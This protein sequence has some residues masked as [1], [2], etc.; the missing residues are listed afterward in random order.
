[1]DSTLSSAKDDGRFTE[2]FVKTMLKTWGEDRHVVDD[3]PLVSQRTRA[4]LRNKKQYCIWAH[5]KDGLHDF[6][7]GADG[8]VEARKE[9]SP[10]WT[11]WVDRVDV[12]YSNMHCVVE[13]CEETFRLLLWKYHNTVLDNSVVHPRWLIPELDKVFRE[14]TF[15]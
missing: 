8:S 12:R 11:R 4:Q 14:S 6:R 2:V 7:I 10:I 1:M 5:T 9:G 13:R 15:K 3:M